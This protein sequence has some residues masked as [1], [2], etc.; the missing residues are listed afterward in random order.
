[1]VAA[2]LDRI[3]IQV[4]PWIWDFTMTAERVGLDVHI[5]TYIKKKEA[6]WRVAL[7]MKGFGER[8]CALWWQIV[9]SSCAGRRRVGHCTLPQQVV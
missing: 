9:F 1:M 4:R 2:Y 6:V 8:F 3:K 5:F 7:S